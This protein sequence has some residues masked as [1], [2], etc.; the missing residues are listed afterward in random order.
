MELA[1]RLMF[2]LAEAQEQ[3][4]QQDQDVEREAS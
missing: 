3:A 1:R 4:K 2:L